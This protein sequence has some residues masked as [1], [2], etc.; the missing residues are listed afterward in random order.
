[1]TEI[2]FD[3]ELVERTTVKGNEIV[4][5]ANEITVN[6]AETQE[7]A[8]EF[9]KEHC[10][11][12]IKEVEESCNPRI[13]QAQQLHKSL[14]ADR[15]VIIKPFQDAIDVIKGKINSYVMEERRRAE[16]DRKIAEEK[17]RKEEERLRKIKEEQERKWR[18]K[19]EAARK[20]AAKLEA[21]GKAEEAKKLQELA[22]KAAEKADEREEEK[23]SVYVQPDAVVSNVSKASTVV[24]N[25][26]FEIT[27][28]RKLIKALLDNA[29]LEHIVIVD[30]KALRQLVKQHKAKAKLNGLRVFNKGTVRI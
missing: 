3:T 23:E 21:E 25:W 22:E 8:N 4:T 6:S 29:M 10:K 17:A 18:E 11:K 19:E 26:T 2:K 24:D 12:F 30:Q 16:E 27:D 14:I 20:E 1:M 15:N 13:K 7:K 9:A 28:E 5:T